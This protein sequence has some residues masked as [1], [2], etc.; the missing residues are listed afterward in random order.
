[1]LKNIYKNKKNNNIIYKIFNIISYIIIVIIIYFFLWDLRFFVS[2]QL[3]IFS[4]FSF[5]ISMF[6]Y[7]KFNISNIKLIKILQKL[8]FTN[9]FLALFGLIG[10]LL[11][12]SIFNIIFCENDRLSVLEQ[13]IKFP[14]VNKYPIYFN[15]GYVI[16][17]SNSSNT[18]KNSNYINKNNGNYNPPKG[19]KRKAASRPP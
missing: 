2:F 19:P 1:M 18:T 3:F 9:I 6:I 8:V 17:H 7:D 16:N 12:V 15:R 10:Y 11:D 4:I 5:A 14:F 13:S